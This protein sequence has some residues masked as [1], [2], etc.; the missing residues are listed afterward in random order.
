M[1]GQTRESARSAFRLRSASRLCTGSPLLNKSARA[2]I[3]DGSMPRTSVRSSDSGSAM[4]WRWR[5]LF[6]RLSVNSPISRGG[7]HFVVIIDRAGKTDA[8][9]YELRRYGNR[10]KWGKGAVPGGKSRAERNRSDDFLP[11]R[12]RRRKFRRNLILRFVFAK[13]WPIDKAMFHITTGTLARP[14]VRSNV[15]CRL[16]K[17]RGENMNVVKNEV[18]I[19]QETRADCEPR[20]MRERDWFSRDRRIPRSAPEKSRW[21]GARVEPTRRRPG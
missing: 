9:R 11:R 17:L 18:G 4:L 5:R 12:Y 19:P 15:S 20:S 16:N 2:K 14:I 8:M 3:S 10:K 21:R 1:S 6:P 13:I 7:L